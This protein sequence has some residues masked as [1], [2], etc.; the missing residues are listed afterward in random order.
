MA[1]VGPVIKVQLHVPVAAQQLLT[2]LKAPVPAP[3]DGWALIDTGAGMCA[4][5]RSVV[6]ALGLTAKTRVSITGATGTESLPGYL[7]RMTF[8]EIVIGN[9]QAFFDP[10]IVSESPT[11]L[12]MGYIALLGRDLLKGMIVTYDGIRGSYTL[13]W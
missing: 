12:R 13:A 11:L 10:E 6:T 4:I 2:S 9:S 3:V 1:R 8:P 7:V 5:D